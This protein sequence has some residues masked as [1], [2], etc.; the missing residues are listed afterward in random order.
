[1]LFGLKDKHEIAE[2][3]LDLEE[4]DHPYLIDLVGY[5]NITNPRLKQEIDQN[6]IELAP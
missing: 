5:E 6:A 4:L 2:L 3:K 1:V